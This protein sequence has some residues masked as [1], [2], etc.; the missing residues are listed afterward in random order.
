M[1]FRTILQSAEIDLDRLAELGEGPDFSDKDW[2]LLLQVFSR[3]EQFRDLQSSQ[4]PAEW[5]PLFFSSRDPSQLGEIFDIKGQAVSVQKIPLPQE[6]AKRHGADFIYRCELRC[7][8]NAHLGPG[9]ATVLTTKVPK[10][11]KS[12]ETLNEPVEIRGALIQLPLRE[13]NELGAALFVTTHVKWYPVVGAPTGQL[14]L[15]RHGMDVALLDEVR[16]RQPFVKPEISRE[17]EAFYAALTAL[18]K[19]DQQELVGLAIENVAS[20]ADVWRALQPELL[21]R[22]QKL[23]TKLA[24]EPDAGQREALR[25]AVETAR[26]RRGLAAAVIELAESQRSS[27]APLF[28]QPQEEVGELVSFEGV[29]RRAVRIDVADQPAA[30]QTQS[31]A[32][33]LDP[34]LPKIDAY[35]EVE[36]FTADSQNLPMVCCLLQL[37]TDFPTGDEIREP[38]RIS[39]V[40]F[41]NWRY[42]SRQLTN[43]AGETGEQRQLYTPVLLAKVPTWLRNSSSRNRSWAFGAGIAF[44][45]MLLT[46]WIGMTWLAKRDRLARAAVRRNEIIDL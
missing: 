40:F 41:K 13:D 14:L 46:L 44:L 30:K 32:E 36:I 33:R 43:R 29:A 22:H 3:L 42:R 5:A 25:R 17:G 31:N 2:Q 16:H 39:G 9:G 37:P 12:K 23:Q 7:S 20:K 28:L 45:G 4:P 18:N 15:A 11:W 38:V 1:S 6:L 34:G 27:V 35:Y 19:V 10:I 21:R 26:D 8:V 24:A